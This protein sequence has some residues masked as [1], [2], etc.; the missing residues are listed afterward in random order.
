MKS[1][2]LTILLSGLLIASVSLAQNTTIN[3]EKI[4][5]ERASSKEYIIKKPKLED[6]FKDGQIHPE[7]PRYDVTLTKE[8]NESIARDW[9]EAHI[10]LFTEEAIDKFDLKK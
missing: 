6:Y 7:F 8:E 2:K 3:T 10:I 4:S 9:A 1:L 5:K